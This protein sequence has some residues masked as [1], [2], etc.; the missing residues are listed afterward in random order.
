[1]YGYSVNSFGASKGINTNKDLKAF[2]RVPPT[3]YLKISLVLEN[4]RHIKVYY[5]YFAKMEGLMNIC[6]NVH[7]YVLYIRN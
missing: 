2:V 4:K 3:W 1:M 7:M 5:Y 6:Y